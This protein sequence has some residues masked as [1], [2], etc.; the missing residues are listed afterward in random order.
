MCSSIRILI[1]IKEEQTR[2]ALR[3]SLGTVN[4]VLVGSD[5]AESTS[6]LGAIRASKPDLILMHPEVL[7]AAEARLIVR[8]SHYTR[9]PVIIFLHSQEVTVWE[10][11][12][13]FSAPA[14]SCCEIPQSILEHVEAARAIAPESV[15]NF[16]IWARLLQS[17]AVLPGE[18]SLFV[19]RLRGK[20]GLLHSDDILSI[21][22]VG[23]RRTIVTESGNHE[24]TDQVETILSQLDP[25]SYFEA[26][27]GTWI[28]LDR[29]RNLRNLVSPAAQ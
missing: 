21:C 4:H 18:Q 17:R 26:D 16:R 13:P 25:R 5:L 2:T 20:F 29:M 19:T 3:K 27:P 22:A 12:L 7:D 11:L 15:I 9:L 24:A 10:K 6:L 1:A 28:H 14:I 23:N 8:K